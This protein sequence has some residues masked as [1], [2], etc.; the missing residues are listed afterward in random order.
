MNSSSINK[1]SFYLEML[2]ARYGNG[3]YF[4]EAELSFKSGT[5][6]FPA[7]VKKENGKLFLFVSTHL[8]WK[9]DNPASANYQKGSG[10]ARAY[11]LGLVIAKIDEFQKKYNCPAVIVGD[12]NTAYDTPVIRCAFE[13]GFTHAHDCAVEFADETM[14]YHS[15]GNNGFQPYRNAGF[16][17]AIDHILVRNA[18]DSFVRRFERFSPD[19]YLPLSDH[20]PVYIDVEI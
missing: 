20:S 5:K 1:I 9:S 14:G 7:S 8:W 12:F 18:A 2:K 11:Q 19:Y 10:E 13:H 3:E 17:S 6:S 15:C 4:I 16:R